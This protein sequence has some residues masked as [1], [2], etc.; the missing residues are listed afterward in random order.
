MTQTITPPVNALRKQLLPLVIFLVLGFATLF[1][2][3]ATPKPNAAPKAGV[4]MS[5]PG[6]VGNFWGTDQEVSDAEKTILPKDTGFAKKFYSDG[7]GSQI[8]CQIVL[9]GADK[10]SIHRPEACLRGQGWK[11]EGGNTIPIKLANGKELSVMELVIK[12]PVNVGGKTATL[13]SLYLYWFVSKDGT[14]PYHWER[15]AKTN[16]D[17]L[18]HNVTHRWAYVIVS[19]PVLEGF[20]PHGKNKAQTEEMLKNFISTAAPDIMNFE[21]Q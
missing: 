7:L 14:T 17:L 4:N 11:M 21:K 1:I 10:R 12:R 16:L 19:A 13:S 20:V 9:S 5:L 3:Y 8:N 15:I 6:T 2:C 18:L